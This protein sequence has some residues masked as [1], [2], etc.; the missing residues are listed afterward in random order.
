M[1]TDRGLRA[2]GKCG[3]D[4]VAWAKQ[5]LMFSLFLLMGTISSD[6]IV[7]N[8][9]ESVSAQKFWRQVVEASSHLEMLQDQH[10]QAL[11]VTETETECAEAPVI[12]CW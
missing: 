2:V 12:G 6:P 5:P 8:R 7:Q 3:A 1:R 4:N 9:L 11:I 10:F